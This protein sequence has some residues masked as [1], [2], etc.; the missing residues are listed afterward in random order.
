MPRF[1]ALAI[2]ATLAL[3]AAHAQAP[4]PGPSARVLITESPADFT[5][6]SNGSSDLGLKVQLTAANFGCT[7]PARF[8]VTLSATA[9]GAPSSFKLEPATQVVNFSVEP[10]IYTNDV[11]ITPPYTAISPVS[12]K[13]SVA[14]VDANATFPIAYVADFPGALPPECQA[15]GALPKGQDTKLTNVTLQAAPRPPTQQIDEPSKGLP[16]LG[17]VVGVAT[18]AGLA[19]ARRRRG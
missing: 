8:L 19:L 17:V 3:S 4:A 6:R 18:L 1:V 7:Q 16:S 9:S 14:A 13:A 2:L 15:Q 11:P 5:L 12:L 10:G